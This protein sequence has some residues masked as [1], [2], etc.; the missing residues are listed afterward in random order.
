M[1]GTADYEQSPRDEKLCAAMAALA[2]LHIA[3]GDF[4]QAWSLIL[5][6]RNAEAITPASSSAVPRRLAQ[7]R[8][9]FQ[10]GTAALSRAIDDAIWPGLA[11]L[12]R[13]FIALLPSAIPKALAKLEP[14][15]AVRL[16]LQPCLRDIWH[17]HILFTGDD[18]TGIIDFGAVDIDTPATDVA[19]LLGSL[20]AD[21]LE[22]WQTGL[23]AYST[24]R[25]LSSE[26]LLAARALD[27][28]GAVL[29]GCNWIRWI[30]VERRE[31]DDRQQ[32]VERFQKI[33]SRLANQATTL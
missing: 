32:V 11:P 18:V 20:V 10:Q 26:E 13:K 22:G 28:S 29:A 7:L 5:G 33:I 12:A 14:L 9:L 19:R 25:P 16:E 23:T 6:D 2:Q 30:Y 8:E 24:V 15:A 3:T 4:E 21:D 1:P 31:F 27:A 17:D